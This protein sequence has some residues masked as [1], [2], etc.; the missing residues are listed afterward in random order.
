MQ[1]LELS[2]RYYEEVGRSAI[3]KAFPDDFPL[4]SIG[5]AGEGSECFG[6]DDEISSDHDYGPSFCIW[7]DAEHY[8][9]IGSALQA[10][11]DALPVSFMGY[12]ARVVTPQGGGRV[13]VLETET[14][15]SRFIGREQPPA[16]LR[17]WLYLP[18]DKLAAAS[19]GEIFYDGNRRFS[20]IRR[21]LRGYYPEDVRLKKIAARAAE[22]AQ[23]GQYN[24]S[25]CMRRGDQVAASLALHEFVRSAISLLYLLNRRYMPYYKWMFH[26]TEDFS[27]LSDCRP[28]IQRLAFPDSQDRAWEK[29]YPQD[30]DPW[31]N[32][33]DENVRLIEEICAQ[34]V[35]EMKRQQLTDSDADF[36]EPHAA[37]VMSRISAPELRALHILEG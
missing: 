3:E 4:F 22:A 23:S 18:E 7:L 11:Y 9:S 1:L 2:R 27:I 13:G 8:A 33:R 37:D 32:T 19:N 35:R 12:P 20:E 14:F 6:F 36:L 17:R 10:V 28:L 30:F 21:V 25:R 5:L 26:G 15:Y 16:T 24:Y 29:P 31:I 34:I